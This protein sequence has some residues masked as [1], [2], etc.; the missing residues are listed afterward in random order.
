VGLTYLTLVAVHCQSEWHSSRETQIEGRHADSRKKIPSTK[1]V[2]SLT[3]KT[4][5]YKSIG[6]VG[7]MSRKGTIYQQ[8]LGKVIQR[9]CRPIHTF[10]RFW[11]VRERRRRLVCSVQQQLHVNEPSNFHEQS[12]NQITLGTAA[13]ITVNIRTTAYT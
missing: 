1:T 13:L 6:V 4:N 7:R 9:R 10:L 12:C 3:G 2:L 11:S 5:A 8:N